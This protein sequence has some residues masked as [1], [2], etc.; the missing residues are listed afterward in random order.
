[1]E[2]TFELFCIDL[3]CQITGNVIGEFQRHVKR[4]ADIFEELNAVNELCYGLVD[5]SFLNVKS[6]VGT[7]DLRIQAAASKE[8]QP[9]RERAIRAAVAE[10]K[11]R[12][13]KEL[14]ATSDSIGKCL[15]LLEIEGSGSN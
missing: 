14:K 1:M 5:L 15:K 8:L 13:A 9:I 3:Q 2:K 6:G 11:S 4:I 10:L 7:L 12:L